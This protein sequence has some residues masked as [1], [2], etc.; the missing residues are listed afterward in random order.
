MGACPATETQALLQT[1]TSLLFFLTVRAAFFSDP[2][3]RDELA[4]GGLLASRLCWGLFSAWSYH[5]CPDATSGSH[6]TSTLPR[7]SAQK[8]EKILACGCAR[9]LCFYN[10]RGDQW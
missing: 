6:F 10:V 9:Q 1:C 3:S 2:I 5:K 7:L 4:L 8:D